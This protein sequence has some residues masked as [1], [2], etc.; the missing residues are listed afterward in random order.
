MKQ[1]L[2]TLSNQLRRV[3]HRIRDEFRAIQSRSSWTPRAARPN[4]LRAGN[5]AAHLARIATRSVLRFLTSCANLETIFEPRQLWVSDYWLSGISWDDNRHIHVIELA[6]A[7]GRRR[8]PLDEA[9]VK[10]EE[11]WG[12]VRSDRTQ[13]VIPIFCLQE[14][15]PFVCDVRALLLPNLP[16]RIERQIASL[17]LCNPVDLRTPVGPK[18][19]G[20]LGK[21][22]A[23]LGPDRFVV[24]GNAQWFCKTLATLGERLTIPNN[25]VRAVNQI[26]RIMC[27]Y[28]NPPIGTSVLIGGLGAVFAFEAAF[29]ITRIQGIDTRSSS[30]LLIAC[31]LSLLGVLSFLVQEAFESRIVAFCPWW[32]IKFKIVSWVAFM[33]GLLSSP[34]CFFVSVNSRVLCEATRWGGLLLI[35]ACAVATLGQIFFQ[36]GL[37]KRIAVIWW[38]VLL[39]LVAL[40][41]LLDLNPSA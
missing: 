10:L 20:L 34:V 29:L 40:L 9:I 30:W 38:L 37:S 41:P 27:E 17:R 16:K 28:N 36:A 11:E 19:W 6:R 15:S 35:S 21:T 1:R 5:Q 8:V 12:K 31:V 23:D 13:K 24:I 7:E 22:V 18:K 32:A 3:Y 14:V 25:R 2:V 39:S 33:A 4:L 26:R